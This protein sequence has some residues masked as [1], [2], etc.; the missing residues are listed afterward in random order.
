METLDLLR[1]ST[2]FPECSAVHAEGIS[3]TGSS[4]VIM[5]SEITQ[6]VDVS[7]ILLIVREKNRVVLDFHAH[8][9]CFRAV[10]FLITYERFGSVKCMEPLKFIVWAY[11]LSNNFPFFILNVSVSSHHSS[12]A[13]ATNPL[14]GLATCL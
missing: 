10:I 6:S 3:K 14:K 5:F 13:T 1:Q 8:L 2:E 9:S 11:L 4:D 7:N 12:Y